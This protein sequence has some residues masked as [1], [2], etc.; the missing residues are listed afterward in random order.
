MGWGGGGVC[1]HCFVRMCQICLLTLK[2]SNLVDSHYGHNLL[3]MEKMSYNC[4]NNSYL[5]IQLQVM[6]SS[7]REH[8]PIISL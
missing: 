4:L 6:V 1:N 8:H 3:G 2:V 5:L 7:F